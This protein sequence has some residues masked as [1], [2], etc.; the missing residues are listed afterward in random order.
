MA[1]SNGIE[2]FY[3]VSCSNMFK[4][5]RSWN[6][7]GIIKFGFNININQISLKCSFL[8]NPYI[9]AVI[10]VFHISWYICLFLSVICLYEGI[11]LFRHFLHC[12]FREKVTCGNQFLSCHGSFTTITYFQCSALDC[13][14]QNIKCYIFKKDI[15]IYCHKY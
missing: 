10:D 3:F 2:K 1:K 4:L 8:T 11:P 7:Q 5:F 14:E 9:S 15:L 13:Y 12:K 6:K